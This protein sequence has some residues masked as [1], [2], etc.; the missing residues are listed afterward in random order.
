MKRPLWKRS[1]PPWQLSIPSSP[2]RSGQ[3]LYMLPWP[4]CKFFSFC[5]RLFRSHS[6]WHQLLQRVISTMFL[7]PTHLHDYFV[8]FE[9]HTPRRKQ[10]KRL[11]SNGDKQLS[12]RIPELCF[13][14]RVVRY[15]L[16]LIAV[17]KH[18]GRNDAYR[19]VTL[20]ASL[21]LIFA[22]VA[23]SLA[24]YGLV[25]PKVNNLSR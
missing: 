22:F 16:S 18:L 10:R 1:R 14:L 25:Q 3:Q 4:K 7:C 19:I 8:S 12:V 11:V 20:P 15:P 23:L 21:A 6:H 9:F 5:F 24:L 13:S 17:A 2:S